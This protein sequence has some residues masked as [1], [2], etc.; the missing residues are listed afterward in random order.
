M[1][2]SLTMSQYWSSAGV[3]AVVGVVV[4][5]HLVGDDVAVLAGVVGDLHDRATGRR[6]RR[7]CSR[8]PRRGVRPFGFRPLRGPQQG[9]AAAGEDAFL[10]GGAGGVHGVL[11][12]RLLLLHL[13][14]GRGRRR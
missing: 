7:C 10:V 1:M 2:P 8:S 13:A 5:Q 11:D 12:A 3:V 14:L 6:G 4:L 9:D